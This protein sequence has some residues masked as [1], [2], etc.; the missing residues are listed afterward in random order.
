MYYIYLYW[1]SLYLCYRIIASIF[2]ENICISEAM[3]RWADL[4][5][6]CFEARFE[7]Q[8]YITGLLNPRL[9][10]GFAFF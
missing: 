7:D 2:L 9:Q 5:E 8:I 4:D 6:F 10:L 1:I 3:I